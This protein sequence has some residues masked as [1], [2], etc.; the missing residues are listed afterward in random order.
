MLDASHQ[1]H[2]HDAGAAADLELAADRAA[3]WLAIATETRLR[4][5]L[6]LHADPRCIAYPR[7]GRMLVV[8]EGAGPGGV[9]IRTCWL[10]LAPAPDSPSAHADRLTREALDA[11][12][13]VADLNGEG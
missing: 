5:A 10:E 13:A 1:P 6:P 7:R 8:W 12:A 2:D 11:I 4:D 3:G 9:T